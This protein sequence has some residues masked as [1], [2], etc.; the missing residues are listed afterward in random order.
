MKCGFNTSMNTLLW[1]LSNDHLYFRIILDT[2]KYIMI[3]KLSHSLV[4]W[5]GERVSTLA[6]AL[7]DTELSSMPLKQ[8]QETGNRYLTRLHSHQI[9]ALFQYSS[10]PLSIQNY[11][12]F[13]SQHYT[14]NSKT[15]SQY[16]D[17][18]CFNLVK[19]NPVPMLAVSPLSS[20]ICL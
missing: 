13:V 2:W 1:H 19:T 11:E 6:K 8:T 5:R 12:Y 3:E 9:L 4:I 18:Q 17:T 14:S 7:Y 15:F 10:R 16:D 20:L